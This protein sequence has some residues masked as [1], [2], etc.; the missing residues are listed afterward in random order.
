MSCLSPDVPPIMNA[1]PAELTILAKHRDTVR[2]LMI[3]FALSRVSGRALST[4]CA[5]TATVRDG[6]RMAYASRSAVR[7]DAAADLTSGALVVSCAVITGCESL[8]DSDD[9]SD[10]TQATALVGYTNTVGL[11]SHTSRFGHDTHFTVSARRPD[12]RCGSRGTHGRSTHE[13][14]FSQ[15]DT[16]YERTHIPELEP[17]PTM[18][19]RLDW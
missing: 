18:S 7:D 16:P 15:P 9:D 2:V 4:V 5:R 3:T 13:P 11:S 1:D 19:T 17:E 8:V 14:N 12:S 10:H 6:Y